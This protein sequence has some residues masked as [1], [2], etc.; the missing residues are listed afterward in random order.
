MSHIRLIISD[1]D[2]T[3]LNDHHQIGSI[4]PRFKA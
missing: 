3:I 2:G 1:I 4:D